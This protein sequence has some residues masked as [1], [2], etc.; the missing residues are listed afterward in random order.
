MSVKRGTDLI[1]AGAAVLVLSPVMVAV[2]AAIWLTDR[3]SP[4][5]SA[6]RVGLRG[7]RFKMVKF[8]SMVPNA[9]QIG[10]SSTSSRDPRITG[11]GRVIRAYKIDEL[12]QLINVLRGEMSMVGPRPQLAFAVASYSSEERRLLE[13][14]PGVTDLSSVV[15]SDE[16]EI[17]A[18][19]SDP[20]LAYEQLIRPLKNRI[21]L[22]SIDHGSFLTDLMVIGLTVANSFTRARALAGV[23]WILRRHGADEALIEICFRSR[24][25][26]P[27]APPGLTKVVDQVPPG[28][29]S[30][31]SLESD[32][33]A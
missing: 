6:Y 8:R 14:K 25:L 13:V 22:F 5:Y 24:P 28:M 15:F 27:T 3:G 2:G 21:A 33:S 18:S 26:V 1:L 7:Q 11:I 4:F 12:P 19:E 23:R 30:D 20:D 9:A 31:V 32:R 29:P 10:P 17:L 16:G